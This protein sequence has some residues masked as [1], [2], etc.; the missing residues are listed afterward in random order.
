MEPK[1]IATLRVSFDTDI[2]SYLYNPHQAL[3]SY[4]FT[5]IDTSV[6]TD[7]DVDSRCGRA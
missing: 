6:N 4:P 3:V 2:N 1:D 7:A 5:N